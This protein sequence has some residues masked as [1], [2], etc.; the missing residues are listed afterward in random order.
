METSQLIIMGAIVLAA[1]VISQVYKRFVSQK[2]LDP[3]QAD[4]EAQKRIDTGYGEVHHSA[5][6][7]AA[8]AYRRWFASL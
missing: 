3:A 4:N 7:H 6:A 2:A 8:V 5:S 1:L